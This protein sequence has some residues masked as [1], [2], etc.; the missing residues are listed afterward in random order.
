MTQ[1]NAV[2]LPR[3]GSLERGIR[4]KGWLFIL[5]ALILVTLLCFYPMV[6]AFLL[7]LQSGKGNA[8]KW[9]GMTNYTRLLKD[10][11]FIAAVKNTLFYLVVQVPV[12]LLLAL[13][14][15]TMLNDKTLRGKGVYRTLIFLPCA[16]SLVSCSMV[17]RQLFSVNGFVNTVLTSLNLI[18]DP[19]PFLTNPVWAKMVIIITMLWR[20]T[21]YNMVLYLAGLQNIDSQ[22]YEAARIDGASV[23]QMFTRITAPLLRP[24]IV[25]TTVLSTNG[26]LQLFD[27]VINMTNGGPGNGTISLS[28]YIYRT[29]FQNVPQFGYACAIGFFILI[30]VAV[31]SGLQRKVGDLA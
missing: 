26:T 11:T 9:A 24:V 15:A 4:L 29:T 20:W 21:G 13:I 17:F 31:L 6:Q 14:L 28:L 22:V 8:L 3:P 19:I 30:V 1:S 10:R 16:T 27:E 5:P 18:K 2:R 12:M 7:S 25:F 23:V